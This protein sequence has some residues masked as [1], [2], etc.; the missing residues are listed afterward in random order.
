MIQ[1]AWLS[2]GFNH[3]MLCLLLLPS[4]E[5]AMGHQI[6]GRYFWLVSLTYGSHFSFPFEI[7]RITR[8]VNHLAP[9]IALSTWVVQLQGLHFVRL[10]SFFLISGPT[11]PTKNFQVAFQK[12]WKCKIKI[13]YFSEK[14]KE[15]FVGI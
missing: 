8:L 4:V 6:S 14:I 1:S 5:I 7:S 2:R 11:R 10:V 9:R 3:H 13:M 12:S 15:S